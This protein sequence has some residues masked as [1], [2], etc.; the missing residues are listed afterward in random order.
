MVIAR[1][2]P[3]R[4]HHAAYTTKDME[5]T[6]EFSETVTELSPLATWS[7]SDA[8]SCGDLHASKALHRKAASV[9][10]SQKYDKRNHGGDDAHRQIR[11]RPRA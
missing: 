11:I 1:N 5:K 10:T 2:L 3:S 4:L 8:D 7:A 9:A 6:R